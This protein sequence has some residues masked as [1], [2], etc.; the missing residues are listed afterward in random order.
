LY[1]PTAVFE[2]GVGG[3]LVTGTSKLFNVSIRKRLTGDGGQ[4]V[5]AV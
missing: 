1:S 5:L 4:S 2:R 3:E